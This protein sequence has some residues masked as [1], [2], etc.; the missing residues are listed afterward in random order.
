[1]GVF[2][3]LGYVETF[4]QQRFARRGVKPWLHNCQAQ[5]L[6]ESLLPDF[7]VSKA[8]SPQMVM[9]L[10]KAFPPIAAATT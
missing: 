3:L 2:V 7:A 6:T 10:I 9:G 1:M 4:M 8:N 5:A